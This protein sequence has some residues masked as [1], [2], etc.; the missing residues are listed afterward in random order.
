MGSKKIRIRT[1][2]FAYFSCI[3]FFPFLLV[4]V[5]FNIAINYYIHVGA[6]AQLDSFLA[7][8]PTITMQEVP[9]AEADGFGF[10]D[11]AV[12]PAIRVVRGIFSP[13]MFFVDSNYNLLLARSPSVGVTEILHEAREHNMDFSNWRNQRIRASNHSVYYVSS[14]QMSNVRTAY[15]NI[16]MI[17][18]VD[19]TSTLMLANRVNVILVLLVGTIFM[20]AAS[21]AYFMSNSITRPIEKLG[22]FALSIGAGNFIA[23]DF[24]FKDRELHELSLAINKSVR[25]LRAYDSEQKTFFQ[26]VSHELRTPLMSIKCYAEGVSFGLMEPKDACETILQ[27]TDKL[28]ELVTDML[29]VSRIDN[30][31]TSYKTANANIAE[32]IRGCADRQRAMADKAGVSFAFDLEDNEIHIDC[33]GELVSRAIDNLISNAIRYAKSK[34][35]LSCCMKAGNVE[36]VVADDGAGIEPDMMP[37]VFERFY[38][39]TGGNFGIGLSIVKSIAQQH[40]GRVTAENSPDGGAV[41]TVTLPA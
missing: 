15:G 4:G 19:V 28:S 23:N 21:V 7:D 17:A 32:I 25:Q 36:I 6:V 35:V 31:G 34:I 30:I 12:M 41:F 20:L 8:E 14:R 11:D 29:Y 22:S 18:Y 9:G 24:E 5:A 16:Y 27:E 3:L 13:N 26:N 39:G 10:F 33:M 2:F 37:H 1:R 38:K 40:G